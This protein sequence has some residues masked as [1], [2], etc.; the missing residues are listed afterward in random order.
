M[1]NATLKM[2][3]HRT[4]SYYVNVLFPQIVLKVVSGTAYRRANIG[5]RRPLW[6]QTQQAFSSR[7]QQRQSLWPFCFKGL[8]FSQKPILP[9]F[10]LSSLWYTID[11]KRLRLQNPSN[12][13][14]ILLSQIMSILL[15]FFL[16]RPVYSLYI[17]IIWGQN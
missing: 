1:C 4:C 3:T 13:D 2:I 10:V 5:R 17:I 7:W 8:Y 9:I 11:V 14:P 16:P 15:R 12:E 6:T